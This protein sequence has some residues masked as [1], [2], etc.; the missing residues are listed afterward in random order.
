[1]EKRRLSLLIKLGIVALIVLIGVGIKYSGINFGALSPEKIETF[2]KSLGIW[3]PIAYMLFYVVRPLV[4]FPAGLLTAIG[5]AVFGP[6]LGTVYT[7]IGATG[8]ALWEFLVARYVGREWIKKKI[9]HHIQKIDTHLEKHG[10]WTLLLIRLIPNLP[11]DV[12]NYGLGLTKIGFGS[13]A[14]G[15]FFGIIPGT[16]AFCYL[17]RSLFEG[18]VG[19]ILIA[20]LIIAGLIL[21][22]RW[23]KK[24][25]AAKEMLTDAGTLH[26]QH[27]RNEEIK[28]KKP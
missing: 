19:K 17:G 11:Y 28:G 24:K 10:I 20:A 15:T 8:C 23:Y 2:I 5:G 9:G 25:K 12:Q 1:M 14:V 16:F 7:V 27:A 22:Q 13:Y 3:G 21:L 26:N 6:L 4:L 18:N